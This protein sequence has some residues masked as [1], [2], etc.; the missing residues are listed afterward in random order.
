MADSIGLPLVI[1]AQLRWHGYGS[2]LTPI[3]GS[4]CL[5]E[6]NRRNLPFLPQM[7]GKAMAGRVRS[8]HPAALCPC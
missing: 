7:A 5:D 8:P 1:Q 6:P 4:S 3:D 2:R